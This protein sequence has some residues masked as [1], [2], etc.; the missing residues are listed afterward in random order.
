MPSPRAGWWIRVQTGGPIQGGTSRDFPIPQ[1]GGCNIPTTAAAYSL[2][3]TVVPQGSLGYLTIWPTGEGQPVVSTL[4]SLDGRIKADAA[5][6]PAGTNGEVSVYVTNTTNVVL[7]INGYFAPASG[8]TLAFYPLTPCR[9][10]DTRRSTF[11]QGLGS[12]VPD[13]APRTRLPHTQCDYLQHSF[14]RRRL[15]A[16][17]HGRAPRRRWVT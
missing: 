6:V 7:D 17:L 14:Q 4:N 8:S 11:P 9:V 1:E 2:N 12:P 10:A 5:I 15:F 16:Q 13:R 3:V